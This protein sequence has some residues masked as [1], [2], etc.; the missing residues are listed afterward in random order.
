MGTVLNKHPMLGVASDGCL[1]AK[2]PLWGLGVLQHSVGG[3]RLPSVG[4]RSE[5]MLWTAKVKVAVAGRLVPQWWVLRDP[6]YTWL[7]DLV[8]GAE[9]CRR[10]E[11]WEGCSCVWMWVRVLWLGVSLSVEGGVRLVVLDASWWNR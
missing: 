2:H 6:V 11:T 8:G 3:R 10:L 1:S 9:V 4:V 7:S 5:G